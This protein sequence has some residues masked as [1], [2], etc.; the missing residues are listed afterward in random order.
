MTPCLFLLHLLLFPCKMF[1]KGSIDGSL[2]PRRLSS[3]A[4]ATGPGTRRCAPSAPVPTVLREGVGSTRGGSSGWAEATGS[5]AT[6]EPR[7]AADVNHPLGRGARRRSIRRPENIAGVHTRRRSGGVGVGAGLLV[8]GP[9]L[10]IL[11]PH[12]PAP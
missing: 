2:G 1:S 5:K 6:K 8:A 7:G 12:A 3:S 9:A 4:D 11:G 10:L